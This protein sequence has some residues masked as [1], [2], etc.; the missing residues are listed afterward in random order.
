MENEEVIREQMETTRSS[1]TEKLETL[2]EKLASTVQETT[3]A[4][5]ETVATVKETV[6]EGV[7]AVHETVANV[8]E[9]M[10]ESVE[11]VKDWLDVCGHVKEHP[12]AMVGGSVAVGF[13]VGLLTSQASER[14]EGFPTPLAGSG[15]QPRESWFHREESRPAPEPQQARQEDEGPS[16][17]SSL[18]HTFEPEL[19]KLKGMALGALL[20]TVRELITSQVPSQLGRQIGNIIDDATKKIGGEPMADVS[21]AQN[22]TSCQSSEG[23]ARWEQQKERTTQDWKNATDAASERARGGVN[24]AL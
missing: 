16:A 21:W 24:Q 3:S 12:W 22:L 17:L 5:S 18:F 10:H 20:G 11:T 1:L 19:N 14:Q 6:H 13:A 8:K 2:E 23:P 9:S 4:V 15:R 7:E